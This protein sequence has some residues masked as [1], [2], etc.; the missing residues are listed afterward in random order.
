MAAR[1]APNP[2]LKLGQSRLRVADGK[3]DVRG[4]RVVDRSGNSVGKVDDLFIDE[5][6]RRVR[7]IEVGSGGFLGLGEAKFL[8]PVELVTQVDDHTVRINEARE[9]IVGAPQYDP[10]LAAESLYKDIYTYYGFPPSWSAGSAYQS[11]SGYQR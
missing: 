2:L 4:R 10:G 9:R 5:R 6:E 8:I 11:I 3:E 7:L 1:A